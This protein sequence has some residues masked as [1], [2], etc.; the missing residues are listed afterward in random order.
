[1]PRT[2]REGFVQEAIDGAGVDRGV[3]L[4]LSLPSL[5]F[6]RLIHL[7]QALLVRQSQPVMVSAS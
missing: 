1:M 4:A 6:D 7:V 5:F 2:S 3:R